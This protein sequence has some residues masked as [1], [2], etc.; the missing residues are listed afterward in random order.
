[1]GR[2]LGISASR[3]VWGNSEIAVRRVLLSAMEDGAQV[4]FVRLGDL[5][6]EPCRGCFRCLSRE[7]ACAIGDDVA[8]LVDR[9]EAA[10]ALVLAAP[11]YFGMPPAVLVGLMD[12]LLVVTAGDEAAGR[13]RGAVAIT[14]MGNPDWRGVAQPFVNLAAS[15]LGFDL[16]E[17]VSVVAEGPGEVLMD[18]ETVARLEALGRWLASGAPGRRR[19][20]ASGP[21]KE[22]ALP[23]NPSAASSVQ[24]GPRQPDSPE[25]VGF[26]LKGCR[27]RGPQDFG[28]EARR[29]A[30]CPV[31]ESDFFRVEG[32]QIV[33]PVCGA[34]GDLTV[35]TAGGEFVKIGGDERWGTAWLRRHVASWIKPSVERYKFKREQALRNIRELKRLYSIKEGEAPKP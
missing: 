21:A 14:L 15:L 10:D 33:C 9:A 22:M 20:L 1:L 31:C 26:Q 5:R 7:G 17:S 19:G 35:H 13:P 32:N 34:R 23:A 2:I 25:G 30:L 3:R 18:D 12:R 6:I 24:S 16:I 11:V 8:G 27:R 28:E 4:D 29:G